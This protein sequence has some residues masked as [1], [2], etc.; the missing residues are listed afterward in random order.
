MTANYLGAVGPFRDA[1]RMDSLSLTTPEAARC[2]ACDAY[3]ELV[4]SYIDMDS[5]AAAD[6]VARD[7]VRRQPRS[8]EAWGV[9][10]LVLFHLDRN[11]EGLEA[12]ATAA[13]LHGTAGVGLIGRVYAA[14]R[15][16]DLADALTLLNSEEPDADWRARRS[17][18]W[19]RVI[20]LRYAGRPRAAAVVARQ[21]LVPEPDDSEHHPQSLP[22]GI[23]AFE[24]NE[25]DTA[26]AAFIAAAAAAPAYQRAH[27]G[28]VARRRAWAFTLRG[29][30]AAAQGDT[31]TL[32]LLAD[33][34]AVYGPQSALGR[35][36]LLPAYLHG[37]L[38]EAAHRPAAAID[39]FR[40][41]AYSPTEGFTRVN[42]ELARTLAAVGRFREAIYWLEAAL[43]GG[44]EGSNLYITRTALHEQLAQTFAAAGQVDSARVQFAMVAHAW[45]DAEP[46]YRARRDS[47][48]AYL[49]RTAHSP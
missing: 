23:A 7:W 40:V 5:L 34:V 9:R 39:S 30:V 14:V 28:T 17:R 22:L 25:L 20:A 46:P 11:A 15:R 16:N 45:A 33:T 29:T 24:A 36:R 27:P 1:V 18:V 43:R 37:L 48:I 8:A 49:A 35:D 2:V 3:G 41:A 38:L 13:R 19:W 21:L 47:A 4:Q 10:G 42:A 12:Q 32:R 44:I 26:A 31:A 6:S